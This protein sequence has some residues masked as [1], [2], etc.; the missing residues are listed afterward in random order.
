MASGSQMW[1]QLVPPTPGHPSHP[2]PPHHMREGLSRWHPLRLRN[3]EEKSTVGSRGRLLQAEPGQ[4]GH[5]DLRYSAQ[6]GHAS[7]VDFGSPGRQVSQ[8]APLQAR[9][10][11]AYSLAEATATMPGRAFMLCQLLLLGL[12]SQGALPLPVTGRSGE[13]AGEGGWG[14]ISGAEGQSFRGKGREGCQLSLCSR[15][16]EEGA[17]SRPRHLL[18]SVL[19]PLNPSLQA[20]PPN[21]ALLR[22]VLGNSLP[23]FPS[24]EVSSSVRT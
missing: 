9:G 22:V 5:A 16:G 8:P 11:W 19:P 12:G 21:H 14:G 10:T 6:G 7:L 4:Q 15:L 1:D 18:A 3:E 2:P 13:A 23:R 24:L 17:A 20:L